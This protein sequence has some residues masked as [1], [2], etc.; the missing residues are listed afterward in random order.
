MAELESYRTLA[1]RAVGREIVRVRVRDPRFLKRGLTA[2][3]L[4]GSLRGHKFDRVRRVGKLLV[5]RVAPGGHE[6]AVH[7][8]M[9]GHLLVDG[10]DVTGWDSVRAAEP[11]SWDC[12]ILE[13]SDGGHCASRTDAGSVR[14]C[15]TPT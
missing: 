12:V 2:S 14:S 1:R 9:T 5:F 11:G 4:R 15:S 7:L 3:A 8:G 13:F 10:R 6:V